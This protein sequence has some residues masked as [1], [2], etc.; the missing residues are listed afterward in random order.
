MRATAGV[1]ETLAEVAPLDEAAHAPSSPCQRH[2]LGVLF[3]ELARPDALAAGRPPAEV[4]ALLGTFFGV[5]AEVTEAHGGYSERCD[6]CAVLCVFRAPAASTRA[7][8]A[9]LACARELRDRLAR[10]L[11]DVGVGI[12]VS[13]GSSVAGWIQPLR[14]FEPLAMC[15]P[16]AEARR[17]CELAERDGRWVL[18]SERALACASPAEADRWSACCA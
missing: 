13:A 15:A 16:A 7:A 8:D 17:L 18:P 2:D 3:V 14:R 5:V 1:I 6:L 9:A 12:G 11:P 10:E 4:A